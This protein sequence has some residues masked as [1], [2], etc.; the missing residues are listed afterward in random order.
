M[1]GSKW[2]RLA[3]SGFIKGGFKLCIWAMN[4]RTER[5]EEKPTNLRRGRQSQGDRKK[6]GEK[7]GY[8]LHLG[9][10]EMSLFPFM[11]PF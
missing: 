10:R 2:V 6:H 8:G 3:L 9:V 4:G 7:V 1:E 5:S 11:K